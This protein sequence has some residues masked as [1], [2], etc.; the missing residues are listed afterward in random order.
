[1]IVWLASYP[2][3]G[4]T[5]VRTLLHSAFGLESYSLHCDEGDFPPGHPVTPPA[6]IGPRA[7]A[8]VSWQFQMID[9]NRWR[10]ALN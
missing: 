3:S 2:R 8:L 9:T 7:V 10:W 6:A 4:N 1:M 5:F